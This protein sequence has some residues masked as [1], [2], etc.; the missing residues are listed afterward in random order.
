MRSADFEAQDPENGTQK[1]E[2][3]VL[4]FAHYVVFAELPVINERFKRIVLRDRR[5]RDCLESIIGHWR[6]DTESFAGVASAPYA[7]ILMID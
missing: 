7:S 6:S 3:R 4:T 5:I 1:R 2:A